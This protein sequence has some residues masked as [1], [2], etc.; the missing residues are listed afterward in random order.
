[1]ILIYLNYTFSNLYRRK[2]FTFFL[3]KDEILVKKTPTSLH[4]K[5]TVRRQWTLILIVWVD[6]HMG[7]DPRPSVHMRAP[8]PDPLPPPCGRHNWMAPKAL[9]S[10]RQW[11]AVPNP[12]CVN[13]STPL[14]RFDTMFLFC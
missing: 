5:K 2:I 14:A 10:F 11:S 8:E 1:M 3:S 6:V 13:I 7:L 9:V 4:E 12:Y